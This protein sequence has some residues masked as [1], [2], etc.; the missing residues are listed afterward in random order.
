VCRAAGAPEFTAFS[1]RVVSTD[2]Q[3]FTALPI[4]TPA[5]QDLAKLSRFPAVPTGC[6][7]LLGGARGTTHRHAPTLETELTISLKWTIANLS[8]RPSHDISLL[9]ICSRPFSF[10][11]VAAFLRGTISEW[12]ASTGWLIKRTAKEGVKERERER[13][14]ERRGGRSAGA[15]PR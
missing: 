5:P 7:V 1:P 2:L 14:R 12:S 15:I 13:E 9:F 3:R 4:P 6:S 11:A 10:A 8:T